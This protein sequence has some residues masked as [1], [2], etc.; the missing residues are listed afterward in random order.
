MK[1]SI[2]TASYNYEKYIKETIESIINQTYTNW[3]L[4]IIDDGSKDNSI[5]I[6]KEYCKKDER[7]KLFQHEKGINKGLAETLKLGISKAQSDW[8]IFLEADDTIVPNYIDKKLSVLK[9]N[10]TVNFIFNDI[11]I[12]YEDVSLKDNYEQYI[13]KNKQKIEENTN[14]TQ[15]IN[16][17][18]NKQCNSLIPTFSCVMIR[19]ELLSNIDFCSPVKPWLDYYLWLQIAQKTN[20]YYI[21]EKLTNWRRHSVSYITK[22]IPELHVI[23]FRLKQL[24][25]LKF[26]KP[27][28]KSIL[29]HTR[30][31]IIKVKSREKEVILFD[32]FKFINWKYQK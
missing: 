31:L 7:I 2:I 29:N 15:L 25:L 17:L 19:K 16:L 5:E 13:E 1:I 4:I 20:C 9:E 24:V 21:N 28:L 6:I 22:P 27:V 32:K 10:N 3:E 14:P 26:Y 30:K 8:I 18:R 11:N 12:I 23:K